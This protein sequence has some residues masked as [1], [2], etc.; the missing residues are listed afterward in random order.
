MSREGISIIHSGQSSG[1][2]ST[3]SSIN[4]PCWCVKDDCVVA[5]AES[6]LLTNWECACEDLPTQIQ[7]SCHIS[8]WL[9]S[10]SLLAIRAFVCSTLSRRPTRERMP[11]QSPQSLSS[12]ESSPTG[13][14]K[15][16]LEALFVAFER[17]QGRLATYFSFF[18]EWLLFSA[19]RKS[20]ATRPPS[21]F[22][23]KLYGNISLRRKLSGRE[24]M[25][26]KP[27]TY[28]SSSNV[29][30][31]RNPSAIVLATSLEISLKD[32]L[33]TNKPPFNIYRC[34]EWNC[35]NSMFLNGLDGPTMFVILASKLSILHW[36]LVPQQYR[37][38]R[39]LWHCHPVWP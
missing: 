24:Y 12:S 5:L 4:T 1:T 8:L 21:L 32:K 11:Q 15:L 33:N 17:L 37:P 9:F 3:Q 27:A 28:M 20:R 14:F 26:C 25:A 16:R 39:R 7:P 22:P 23:Y 30:F 18:S 38:H 13:E 6:G 35:S 36:P 31:E 2:W 34:S 10:S 29:W 19:Y